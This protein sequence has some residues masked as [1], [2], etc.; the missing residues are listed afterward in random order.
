[1]IAIVVVCGFLLACQKSPTVSDNSSLVVEPGWGISNLCE[2]G[3]TFAQLK[4]ATGDATTRGS[5]Y[6]PFWKR[7]LETW[8]RGDFVLVPS[9]AAIAVIGENQPAA[10]ITFCVQPYEAK[11]IP[12]LEVRRP[13]QGSLGDKLS[14]KDRTISRVEVERAFGTVSS[15]ATNGAQ[16]LAFRVKGDRFVEQLRDAV[17]EVWYPDHG[18]AFQFTSNVVTSFTVYTATATNR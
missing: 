3:M 13:F 1:L 17:E 15:V 2:V 16:A 9:L 14:F 6:E 11:L 5:H 10:F 8:G 18:V 12:G 7:R 4:K